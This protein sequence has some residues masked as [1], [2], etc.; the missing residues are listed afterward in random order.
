MLAGRCTS[1]SNMGDV[2]CG[3]ESTLQLDGPYDKSFEQVLLEKLKVKF[4]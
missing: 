4:E 3:L 2:A 1:V